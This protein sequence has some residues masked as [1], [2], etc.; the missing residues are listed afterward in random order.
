MEFTETPI[1][2]AV[3]LRIVR[4]L[5]SVGNSADEISAETGLPLAAVKAALKRSGGCK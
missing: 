4:G 3:D 5:A 1:L 2:A